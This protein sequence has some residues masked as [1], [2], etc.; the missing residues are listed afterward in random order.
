MSQSRTISPRGFVSE[1]YGFQHMSNYERGD[2]AITELYTQWQQHGRAVVTWEFRMAVLKRAKDLFGRLDRWFFLQERVKGMNATQIAYLKDL[3]QFVRTGRRRV[4]QFTMLE[5][6]PEH[7]VVEKTNDRPNFAQA[8]VDELGMIH[9]H[10]VLT[11]WC[12]HLGG[13]EDILCTLYV[14]FGDSRGR[15]GADA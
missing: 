10:E 5:L 2:T 13:F 3:V 11:K 15:R 7:T 8:L 4:S 14:L 1:G 12:Q 6:L 9:P